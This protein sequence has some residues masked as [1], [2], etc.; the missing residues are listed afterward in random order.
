MTIKE[1]VEIMKKCFDEKTG[2]VYDNGIITFYEFIEALDTLIGYATQDTECQC[3]DKSQIR[4]ITHCRLCGLPQNIKDVKTLME[5]CEEEPALRNESVSERLVNRDL[6]E[7]DKNSKEINAL[8]NEYASEEEIE[9]ILQETHNKY[10]HRPMMC[11][12]SWVDCAS[13]LLG[14]VHKQEKDK[15]KIDKLYERFADVIKEK[16]KYREALEKMLEYYKTG[17][18]EMPVDIICKALQLL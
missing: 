6:E 8:R 11:D 3:E 15:F 2:K 7:L 14:R 16:D 12:C 9:K 5:L 1:A 10:G 4:L 17:K 18:G 13:A